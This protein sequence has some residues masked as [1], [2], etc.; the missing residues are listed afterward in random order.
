MIELENITFRRG[1]RM[2]FE[3]LNLSVQA[4][5]ITAIMGPSGTGKTTL[6]N[7]LTGQLKPESGCVYV[8]GE[9]IDKLSKHAL[10]RLRQ[11]MAMLFQ[12]AALFTDMNVYDNVALPIRENTDLSEA[13]IHTIV[14]MKLQTVGLRGAAHL[15][16]NEL[17]GGMR[18]RV[19]LARAVALDPALIFYDEPF[20]GQDPIAMGMLI[21]LIKMLNKLLKL[22]SVIVSHDISETASIADQICLL[23]DRQIIATGHPEELMQSSSNWVQQFLHARAKGPVPFH[24]PAQ[25][26][27]DDLLEKRA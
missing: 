9:R 17:S 27:Y 24:Y 11:K 1:K 8:F 21:E 10:T 4:G 2:I 16:P 19:A 7:L 25:P 26:Y 18:R 20:A 15:M 12:S 23:S 5:S 6:L 3:H 13:L 22:T 14:L